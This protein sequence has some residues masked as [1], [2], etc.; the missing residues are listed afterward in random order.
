MA[1]A[2][3]MEGTAG[4]SERRGQFLAFRQEANVM[5]CG[6]VVDQVIRWNWYLQ[7]AVGAA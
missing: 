1:T 2:K 7:Q 4:R 3:T 5:R 6:D